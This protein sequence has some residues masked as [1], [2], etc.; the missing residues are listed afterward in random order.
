[1]A[2]YKPVDVEQLDADLTKVAEAIRAKTGSTEAMFFP[3]G[4]VRAVGAIPTVDG[5]TE[6]TYESSASGILPD[7]QNK[8]AESTLDLM[9]MMEFES[10]AVGEL[11]A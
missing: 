4:F 10:S 3:D 6:L 5:N 9:S 1:M 2:K 11:T 7:Y 8:N